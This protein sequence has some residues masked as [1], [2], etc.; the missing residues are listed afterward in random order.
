MSSTLDIHVWVEFIPDEIRNGRNFSYEPGKWVKM[1]ELYARLPAL[2]I[3][4]WAFGISEWPTSLN[5]LVT[6]PMNREKR[7]AELNRIQS[8]FTG[9]AHRNIFDPGLETPA[10]QKIV[11]RVS[12][13]RDLK[14]A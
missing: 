9:A 7:E 3:P 5:L 6:L 2:P 8:Y 1:L 12:Q 11:A 13:Y 10:M 4:V 14:V